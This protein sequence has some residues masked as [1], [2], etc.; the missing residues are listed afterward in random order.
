VKLPVG[1]GAI[2]GAASMAAAAMAEA[3]PP[4]TLPG[5]S[6]A[7]PEGPAA[8][9]GPVAPPRDVGATHPGSERRGAVRPVILPVDSTGGVKEG[10]QLPEL[11]LPVE[12]TGGI[13]DQPGLLLLLP[14]ELTGGIGGQLPDVL[15]V[16]E[17]RGGGGCCGWG[18]LRGKL[19]LLGDPRGDAA[20]GE[21][22]AAGCERPA[23][24]H[25][26]SRG[27]RPNSGSCG[28]DKPR[29]GDCV[30]GGSG[31][32]STEPSGGGEHAAWIST[33]NPPAQSGEPSIECMCRSK[34]VSCN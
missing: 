20:R 34:A 31:S 10:C 26:A 9:A 2:H 7:L 3:P 29:E 33:D 11:L 23:A 21:P 14:V 15:L 5:V 8:A 6:A 13:D 25:S 27:S 30:D 24:A 17:L 12:L 4:P 22:T 28:R 32:L 18:Q 1:G 19:P 16:A